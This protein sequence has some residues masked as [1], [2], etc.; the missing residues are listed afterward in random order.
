MLEMLDWL[1]YICMYSQLINEKIQE[2]H[3]SNS[4]VLLSKVKK[5]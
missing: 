5:N 4:F 3:S 2:I 1:L